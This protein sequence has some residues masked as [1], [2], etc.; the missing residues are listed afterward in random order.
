MT[1]LEF[2]ALYVVAIVFLARWQGRS[3][4]RWGIAAVVIPPSGVALLFLR[5]RERQSHARTR[6]QSR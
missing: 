1:G 4:W 5:D 6:R 3:G 2:F